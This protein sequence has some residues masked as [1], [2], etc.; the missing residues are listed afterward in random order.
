M[1]FAGVIIGSFPRP[2]IDPQVG[3]RGASRFFVNVDPYGR[4]PVPNA[5]RWLYCRG[6]G[7]LRGYD[8]ETRRFIGFITPAGFTP[9]SARPSDRFPSSD[10]MLVASGRA[11]AKYLAFPT[12]VYDIQP[13]QRRV[14]TV[15]AAQAGD[16]VL[17]VAEGALVPEVTGMPA[18]P[19][20]I[21][22]VTRKQIHILDETGRQILTAAMPPQTDS[23]YVA[24][25]G[26]T[27]DGQRYLAKFNRL[28]DRGSDYGREHVMEL[29]ASGVVLREFDL[30]PLPL[31]RQPSNA[32]AGAS[33][34]IISPLGLATLLSASIVFSPLPASEAIGEMVSD[35]G[36]GMLP[37]FFICLSISVIASTAIAFCWSRRNAL[38]R[39]RRIIWTIIGFLLGPVGILL[40]W[41]LLDWPAL[42]A[43]PSCAKKRIVTADLCP[44]C[45]APFPALAPDPA[46]IF[47]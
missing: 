14:R 33:G 2:S 45:A 28:F 43:C 46:D 20:R 39:R 9:P 29:A 34:L 36:G 26:A 7:V 3:Y 38:S 8:V 19:M 31:M 27:S 10:S 11:F 32:A 4:A 30:P 41:S 23:Y 1:N 25:I 21:V 12:M 22:V 44:Q 35:V 24:S 13:A 6:E 16:P 40:M 17:G 37:V 42:V 15:F 47:A 5:G 18:P